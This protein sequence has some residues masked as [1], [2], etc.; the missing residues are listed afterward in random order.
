MST[1][2]LAAG[3]ILGLAVA[4][5]WAGIALLQLRRASAPG[6]APRLYFALF[7]AGIAARAAIESGYAFLAGLGVATLAI[8]VTALVLKMATGLAAFFGLVSYLLLVYSGERRVVTYAGAF[9]V[10]L[11]PFV[12]YAYVSRVPVAVETRTWYAGLAYA[13]P[14]GLLH[15]ATVVL[16]F[17]PPLACTCC[18]A[19]LLRVASDAGQRRRILVT[20][21]ALGSFFGAFLFGWMNEQWFWWGLAERLLAIGTSLGVLHAEQAFLVRAPAAPSAAA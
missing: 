8:G 2:T 4:L 11:A 18:Y 16:L 15:A 1:P 10:T 14:Q 5:L 3:S 19:L 7:W 13:E 6:Q 21:L 9:Y 12:V 17:L 20:S